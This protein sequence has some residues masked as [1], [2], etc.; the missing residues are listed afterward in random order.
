M[1]NVVLIFPARAL[2]SVALTEAK[3][4]GLILQTDYARTVAAAKKLPG[5]TVMGARIK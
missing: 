1:H 3:K 4:L 5:F 2:H